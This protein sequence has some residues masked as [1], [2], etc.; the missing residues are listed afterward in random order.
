M[1]YTT[2]INHVSKNEYRQIIECNTRIRSIVTLGS[3][4]LYLYSTIIFVY[5]NSLITSSALKKSDI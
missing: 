2:F 1:Q 5:L 3:T 4:Y